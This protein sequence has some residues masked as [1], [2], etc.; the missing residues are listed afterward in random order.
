MIKLKQRENNQ[1]H[2]R[3]DDR[4]IDDRLQIPLRIIVRDSGDLHAVKPQ[5]IAHHQC[6]KRAQIDAH[7]IPY[8]KEYTKDD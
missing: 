7:D 3:I 1:R 4:H 8:N 2:Q 6:Q 5:I